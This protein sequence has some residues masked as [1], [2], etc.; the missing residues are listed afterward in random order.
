MPSTDRSQV[1]HIYLDGRELVVDKAGF[2]K[3]GNSTWRLTKDEVYQ[4]ERAVLFNN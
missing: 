2:G 1:Y 4:V 3:E